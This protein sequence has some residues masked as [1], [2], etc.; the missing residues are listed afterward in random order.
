MCL[1]KDLVFCKLSRDIPTRFARH[2]VVPVVRII[3]FVEIL[4][5]RIAVQLLRLAEAARF[6][7]LRP[8]R[9]ELGPR[10]TIL[11]IAPF[12]GNEATAV[13]SPE[14]LHGP[15]QCDLVPQTPHADHGS[16]GRLD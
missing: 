5:P 13:S 16:H 1:D 15:H 12:G 14:T 4:R 8:E 9:A 2:G 10:N 6:G 11:P 3:R 7:L